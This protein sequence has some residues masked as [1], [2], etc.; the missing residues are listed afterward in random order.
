MLRVSQCSA[1]PFLVATVDEQPCGLIRTVY[2]G[3]RTLIHLPPV[4]PDRLNSCVAATLVE[5]A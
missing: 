5:A 1:A 3:S 4:H 2:D